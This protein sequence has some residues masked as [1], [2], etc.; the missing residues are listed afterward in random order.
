MKGDAGIISVVRSS[1]QFF[2]IIG[3]LVGLIWPILV[4]VL[5]SRPAARE[6]C[7]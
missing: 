2:L 3:V 4:G 6:A 5:M 7:A 1:M